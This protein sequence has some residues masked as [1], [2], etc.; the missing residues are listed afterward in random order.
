M[1]VL[2]QSAEVSVVIPC[3]NAAET[4]VRALDSIKN[5]T[6]KVREVLIVDDCSNDDSLT[7]IEDYMSENP[8]FDIRLIK[9]SDN[10]GP[11]ISRNIGWNQCKGTWIA[12]LDADDSWHPRKIEIQM[13]FANKFPE[14]SIFSTL[15]KLKVNQDL[16]SNYIQSDN[17]IKIS[18]KQMLFKNF[19][20][21]RTVIIK[22]N[23]PYRFNKGISEDYGLWLECLAS[24]LTCYR[25]ESELAY[26]HR[27]EFSKGGLSS[28]LFVHELYEL[29]NLVR[30]FKRFPI[31]VTLAVMFSIIKFVRRFLITRLGR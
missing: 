29:K 15:T 7:V 12:F 20:F 26:H 25:I 11:G 30:Y 2:N 19:I 6:L 8:T 16:L 10:K 24:G 17:Y 23:V 9:N 1:E 31:L 3:F 4:I 14:V 13:E 27:P 22:G 18:I 28:R 21:T 5:Q